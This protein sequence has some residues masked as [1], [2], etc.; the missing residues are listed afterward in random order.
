MSQTYIQQNKKLKNSVYNSL[1]SW[2]T[3]LAKSEINKSYKDCTDIEKLVF[4]ID[5]YYS[6]YKYLRVSDADAKFM[7]KKLEQI[8]S[9]FEK[10]ITKLD[11]K[12]NKIVDE[13]GNIECYAYS[14]QL[15]VVTVLDYLINVENDL[16]LKIK[17]DYIDFLGTYKVIEEKDKELYFRTLKII[18]NIGK[19]I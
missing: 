9:Y 14:P 5:R 2:F 13:K 6:K 11:D 7:S 4:N 1:L 15:L 12:G 18:N 8:Q 16:S 19:M 3:Y 10:Q 17:F